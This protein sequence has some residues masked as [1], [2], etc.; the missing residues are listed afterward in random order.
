MDRWSIGIYNMYFL[1]CFRTPPTSPY[2]RRHQAGNSS[3]S[4][5]EPLEKRS[6][7]NN[8]ER[9]RRVDLRNA[10]E[11]LRVLVPEVSSR[12]R[13]AKVVIL[14]EASLYCNK[15]G[16]IGMAMNRKVEELRRQ[17]ERLRLRVSQLRRNLAAKR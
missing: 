4:D 1:F 10:F 3:D 14:R 6:M 13:A 12:E 17:Q 11:D 9:Q 15:L 2:K 5:L 16:N 8:M 7:H